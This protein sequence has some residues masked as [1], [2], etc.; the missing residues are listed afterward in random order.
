MFQMS[1]VV[2]GSEACHVP[3]VLGR[4]LWFHEREKSELS[5]VWRQRSGLVGGFEPSA[6]ESLNV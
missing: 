5:E 2:S 4:P 1:P 3:N 6:M